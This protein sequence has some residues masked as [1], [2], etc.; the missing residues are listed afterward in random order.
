M[1]ELKKKVKDLKLNTLGLKELKLVQGGQRGVC[2]DES[3]ERRC[4]QCKDGCY[5]GI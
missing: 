5:T 3:C 4:Y 2:A 1:S